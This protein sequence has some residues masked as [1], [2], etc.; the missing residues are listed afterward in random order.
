MCNN[1]SSLVDVNSKGNYCFQTDKLSYQI[2]KNIVLA[3]NRSLTYFN[4]IL[5]HAL[6]G[7]G[8]PV[9]HCKFE[10]ISNSFEAQ[11]EVVPIVN[12]HK[13]LREHYI[14]VFESDD[15]HNLILTEDEVENIEQDL[16][17]GDQDVPK[18][19]IVKRNITI[20]RDRWSAD[21]NKMQREFFEDNLLT[22]NN[23]EQRKVNES[24]NKAY[25]YHRL[26][27]PVEYDQI[28]LNT[29]L[30]GQKQL[31]ED[32]NF[33]ILK[34]LDKTGYQMI[35][36]CKN[37]LEHVFEMNDYETIKDSSKHY[38]EHL[39]ETKTNRVPQIP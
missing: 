6:K 28:R 18:D 2:I 3:K 30:D 10:A 14:E 27:D 13:K 29:S 20:N 11:T 37:M 16:I 26:K 22:V 23:Q 34:N 33:A 38:L 21:I 35:I 15:K 17:K 32:A 5:D 4:E 7:N 36:V 12:T 24:I 25:R 1:V 9:E 8:I 39:L 19:S 31:H